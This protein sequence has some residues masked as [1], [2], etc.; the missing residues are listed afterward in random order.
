MGSVKKPAT[1]MLVSEA[2]CGARLTQ[3]LVLVAA[4]HAR[5]HG[6]RD[7]IVIGALGSAL[8]AVAASVARVNGYDLAA[9]EALIT[10]HVARVLKNEAGCPTYH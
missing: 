8:A 5:E 10:Q 4:E 7:A 9:F 6:L 3:A 1:E 2:R